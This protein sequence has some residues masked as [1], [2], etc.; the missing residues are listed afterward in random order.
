[1][2]HYQDLINLFNNCFSL[3]Y[4]TRL[5]KG[6]NEPL[7]LPAAD[8]RPYHQ[9]FFAHGF[10]SSALHECSHWL[11]A[12]E[13]RRKL[14]DFGYWYEPDGRSIEQQKL[15][16]QVEVKPQALEWIFS[17][18]AKHSFRVSI[19]NL[20][21]K[22]TESKSFKDAVYQ[23]V[24]SLCQQGLSP[25]AELFHQTLCRFYGNADELKIEDFDRKMLA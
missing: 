11:I 7:Y 3:K 18:A 13:E 4:N 2:H 24:L 20:E 9:L 17:V 19:D 14:V 15:F 5:V 12:G 1:M 8:D 23:Q 25:R 16:Q 6:D 10:F 21:G 22:E